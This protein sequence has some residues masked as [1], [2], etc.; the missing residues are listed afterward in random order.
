MHAN[1]YGADLAGRDP[2]T[3]LRETPELL[4]AAVE[5]WTP[6]MFERSYAPGKWS[7]RKILTHLA[8][9]ELALTTR[10]RLALSVPDYQAQSFDQDAWMPLDE[11]VDERTALYA[12]LALRRMNLA[13]WEGLTAEQRERTFVHPEFGRLSVAWIAAQ[14]AG[15]DIHHLKQIETLNAEG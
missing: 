8:Q 12:Y 1:P 13:M 4:R 9:M 10:A 14:M 6:E 3:A 2:F 5:R 15:H 11:Q 7:V